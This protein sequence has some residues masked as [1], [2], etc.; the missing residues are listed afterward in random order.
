MD[1]FEDY[2]KSLKTFRISEITESTHRNKLQDLLEKVAKEINP[3]IEIIHEP[4][5]EGKFGSPDYKVIIADNIIGYVENKPIGKDLD[6]VIR[7]EQIEK[8]KSLSDNLIV[9]NYIEFI[10]LKDGK[11][12][13]RENLSYLT[14]FERKKTKPDSIREVA[15]KNLIKNFFS[16]APKGISNTKKLAEAL[17]VR[18]KLLEEILLEELQIQEKE[19]IEGK[20]YG[21]YQTFKKFVFNELDIHMFS[22]TFAQNLVYGLFLARLNADTQKVNL[23]NA[24]KYI[25]D[26]F[27]LIR[28]LVSFLDELDKEEYKET[29]WIVEEV[30]TIMNNL[31]L[32]SINKTLSFNKIAKNKDDFTVKDPYI[33]FYEDFLAS[34]DKKL[35]KSKGVYYTPPP[36]VNF[37]VRSTDYILRNTF[38]LKDGFAD[39]SKVTV[40]DFAIGTGTFLLEILKQIFERIPKDSGKRDLII[41]DHI[42]KNL[43]GF[44]YLIAPYTIA[45]LKLSQFL[46]DQSYIMDSKERFQIFLTNTLEPTEKQLKI[47]LLPALSKETKEAQ[48]VKDKPI[49][50]ITGNPPYSGHSKNIGSWIIK[51]IKDYYFVDESPLGEKNPKWLQDDYVKFIRFAQDKIDKVEE[52]IVSII[53]NHSFLDNPTFRGMRQSLM[54]TFNQIYLLDLHGNIKKREE[55][56]EGKKDENVFDIEQGVSISILIKN[57]KL[58]KKIFISDFWGTRENKYKRC[59]KENIKTIDWK[60]IK[61]RSPQYL[62]KYQ[63]EDLKMQYDKF[64]SLK[65]IFNIYGVGITTAHDDFVTSRDEKT[66]LKRFEEFKKAKRDEG[67]LRRIFNVKEKKGWN[68][69]D[70]W[71]NLQKIEKISTI[72]KPYLFRPFDKRY[73]IYEDKLVW[74]TVRKIMKHFFYE[75]IGLCCPRQVKY[76]FKHSFVINK[77]HNFNI[78]DTAGSLGSGYTFPLY[79]YETENLFLN[80][81]EYLKSENF[82]KEFRNYIYNLYKK[83]YNPKEILGYIYAILYSH[84]YR[85]KYLTFLKSDFP[86]LPFIESN[87][88]FEKLSNIGINLIDSHLMKKIPNYNH[89]FFTKKGSYDVI[90][91]YHVDN[92]IY[93]NE[94]QYFDKVTKDIYRFYIGGYQILDKYLKDRKDTTLTLEEI[95]NI[96]NIIKVIA[97]TIDQMKKIDDLTKDWI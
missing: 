62:F 64:Y 50:V 97:Y 41:K 20:L 40:L 78:L 94:S 57:N 17:A 70:G 12:T 93:I 91:P 27:E 49:L 4:K 95:E 34:Y 71:D 24:K 46:K 55:T 61:P 69:L 29:R 39:H 6:K 75:N 85:K 19:H 67:Y 88:D 66:L 53:T 90:G 81:K 16:Q 35:K 33:Y 58:K 44:E 86:K 48:K 87:K 63:D 23:Y 54:N 30:L 52:G 45:H 76:D 15:V 26:S 10:W 38:S 25:P 83:D 9:T 2:L 36:V 92:K 84:R 96:E 13:K 22:D 21:L 11:V 73:I 60:E 42:L 74:R 80:G 28:E 72:I 56:P 47:P 37:I 68:I 59:L 31:D 43:Y 82:K 7:S 8:Y 79:T 1:I 51:K 14:D 65:D 89:G 18:A 77:I 3:K 5:R 32:E